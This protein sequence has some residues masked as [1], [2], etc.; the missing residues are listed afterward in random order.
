[1]NATI[2]TLIILV[3]LSLI[4]IGILYIDKYIKRDTKFGKWWNN[5]ICQR[6]NSDDPNF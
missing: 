5:N 1:M 3:S 6:L 4:F 2:I